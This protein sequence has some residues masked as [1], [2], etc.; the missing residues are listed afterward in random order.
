VTDDHERNHA[1]VA[2]GAHFHLSPA[3]DLVPKPSNT[4]RRHLSLI[5]GEYGSL[6]IREN[7]LSRA[8]VFHLTRQGANDVIDEVQQIVRAQWRTRLAERDV[9]QGDIDR[10]ASCFDAP[11]FEAPAPE[12]ATL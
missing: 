1:L 9:S 8:E 12:Q 3:F 4:H 11:S 7:L 10:I 2:Q 5:V 6:A